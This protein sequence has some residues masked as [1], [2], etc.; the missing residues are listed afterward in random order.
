M[1]TVLVPVQ[2]TNHPSP[3]IL[4]GMLPNLTP[5]EIDEEGQSF[6]GELPVDEIDEIVAG[7]KHAGSSDGNSPK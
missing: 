4:A 5:H 6:F 2:R 1:D 3:E 7:K